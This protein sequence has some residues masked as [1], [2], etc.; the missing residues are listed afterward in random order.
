MPKKDHFR[1]SL[2]N[3]LKTSFSSRYRDACKTL[4]WRIHPSK[5]EKILIFVVGA[6]RSGTGMLMNIFDL[7]RR[8]KMFQETSE[9]TGTAH[10]RL[11]L[12][13]LD[14]VR[15]IIAKYPHPIIVA[16]LLVESQRTTELLSAFPRSRAVWLYRDFEQVVK[17]NV[18][19]FSSQV[20]NLQA[21]VEREPNNWRTEHVSPAT[22]DLISRHYAPEMSREDAA[23]LH[24]LARNRVYFETE[25]DQNPRVVI[26][27]YN[28]L[29][30]QPEEMSRELYQR[31][32]IEYPEQDVL[33]HVD[34]LSL[35][36]IDNL[37]LHDE[38]RESCQQL[39]N[40]LNANYEQS[41]AVPS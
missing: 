14:A 24:W 41:L 1:Y 8:I 21:I 9:I 28:D 12:K 34:Q 23:A 13:E 4:Y 37:P 27:R 17:S 25:L 10:G 35:K 5:T 16:K 40:Q 39:M 26:M 3:R 29:V 32:K 19:R 31:L 18:K 20:R 33:K 38:I 36:P 2:S 15:R 6:Q 11:R 22:Y 7:D 30:T